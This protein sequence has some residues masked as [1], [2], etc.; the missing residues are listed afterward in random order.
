MVVQA[1]GADASM[2]DFTQPP[3]D[4]VRQGRRELRRPENEA[5]AASPP[6]LAFERRPA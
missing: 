1:H 3:P 4:A 5:T 2:K 6:R